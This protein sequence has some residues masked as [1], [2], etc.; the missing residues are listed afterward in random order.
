M[1]LNWIENARDCIMHMISSVHDRTLYIC[2]TYVHISSAY[3]YS[4][5]LVAL[6]G[7]RLA[8]KF[9]L[10]KHV[11]MLKHVHM[12]AWPEQAQ[13]SC[14]VQSEIQQAIRWRVRMTTT[15]TS[16]QRKWP[17]LSWLPNSIYRCSQWLSRLSSSKAIIGVVLHLACTF[18][19]LDH[20]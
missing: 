14:V 8:S 19:L 18:T 2:R 10:L 7:L 17:P 12:F 20:I 13:R 3:M 6:V 4:A 9:L 11:N 5:A 15:T 1:K 16:L